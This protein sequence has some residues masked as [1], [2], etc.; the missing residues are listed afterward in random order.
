[1]V[2]ISLAIVVMIKKV[3]DQMRPSDILPQCE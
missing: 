1:M 3:Q 2:I